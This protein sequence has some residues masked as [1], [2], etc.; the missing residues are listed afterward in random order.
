MGRIERTL[1]TLDWVND[2]QLRKTTTAESNKGESR[3]S[4]VRAVIFIVSVISAIAVRI[5][6]R[7]GLP[8]LTWLSPPSFIGTQSTP[9][10]SSMPCA[11][12]TDDPGSSALQLVT[13]PMGACESDRRKTW[14]EKT[15]LDEN[16]FCAMPFSS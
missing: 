3:N 4:L 12:R 6:F 2:E 15:T 11:I 16:G 7:S 14:E 13:A 9:A 1:F 8:H 5:T 10:A